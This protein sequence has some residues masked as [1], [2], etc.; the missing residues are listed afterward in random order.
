MVNSQD[1]IPVCQE[2]CGEFVGYVDDGAFS[3]GHHQSQ[4]LANCLSQKYDRL[5]D[6]MKLNRL[7]INPDKTHLMILGSKK[8]SIPQDFS[9]KA[10][11]HV[12]RPSEAEKLLG[13]QIHRS[14]KWAYHI[15]E[16]KDSLVKQLTCRINA[17][18]MV[19]K[20]AG[21]NTRLML[22]NGS[23]HSKLV[24][25]I[26]VWGNAEKY[27]LRALQ[28][29]QLAA[30][31]IVCGPQSVRWSRHK[32]LNKVRWLSIKQLVEFHT[33]LQAYKSMKSGK[34]KSLYSQLT[35]NFPYNIR[36]ASKGNIRLRSNVSTLTFQY[37][38]MLGYNRVPLEV[39]TGSLFTVKRKLKKWV[40][41]NVSL[42]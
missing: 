8:A 20:N 42:D 19:C 40:Q 14:L 9:I 30:A 38:A 10:G 17:L 22:A 32:I 36:G 11:G 31:R 34:P 18:K 25:L 4:V 27:L 16:S 39:M 33:I 15:V 13:G 37:R 35:V 41:G 29:Q 6:W 5:E 12:I 26:N 2:K 24:Y 7:V 21:F 1:P 28:V 3:F 23:F